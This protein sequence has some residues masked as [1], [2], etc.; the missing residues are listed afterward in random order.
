MKEDFFKQEENGIIL[1]IIKNYKKTCDEAY[2]KNG[3]SPE[4]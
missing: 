2:W 1:K 3:N 4:L